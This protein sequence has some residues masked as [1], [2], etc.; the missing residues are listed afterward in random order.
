MQALGQPQCAWIL[1]IGG[2]GIRKGKVWGKR[3]QELSRQRCLA[4]YRLL[5][6]AAGSFSLCFP[7]T[8]CCC[9]ED[10]QTVGNN[11]PVFAFL[12]KLNQKW[13]YVRKEN[14]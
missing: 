6:S 2:Q 1:S 10:G 3:K 5:L 8:R 11:V 7:R 12:V 14:L 9:F 4:L 13:G